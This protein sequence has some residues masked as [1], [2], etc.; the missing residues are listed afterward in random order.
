MEA[1]KVP[2]RQLPFGANADVGIALGII[3]ILMVMIIPLPTTI[4]DILL[5]LNITLAVLILLVTVYSVRPLDFSVFPSLLLITTLFRLSLNIASTRLILL[6]G[7][8]GNHAAMEASVIRLYELGVMVAAATYWKLMPE[9]LTSIRESPRGGTG[10]AG[11]FET[12]LQLYFRP[13]L[14]DMEQMKVENRRRLTS[15]FPIDMFF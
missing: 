12:S 9:S 15:F 13:Y 7:H 2:W 3:G 4:L 14:V 1:I 6:N 5:A 8:G 10:H 11:E